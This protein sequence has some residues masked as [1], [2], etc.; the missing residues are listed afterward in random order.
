MDTAIGLAD[1]QL[2]LD[3]LVDEIHRY[4]AAVDTFRLEGREPVWRDELH[5]PAAADVTR[6]KGD[7][8]L[9]EVSRWDC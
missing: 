1:E 4:L 9:P 5:L 8:S 6:T 3:S 2:D 7:F